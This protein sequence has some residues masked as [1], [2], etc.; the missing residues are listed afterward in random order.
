MSIKSKGGH[1]PK[2]N[3]KYMGLLCNL[4][5]LCTLLNASLLQGTST[6]SNK[7]LWDVSL[8]LS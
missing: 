8:L 3:L 7:I 2:A 6:V 1:I 5:S 4:N